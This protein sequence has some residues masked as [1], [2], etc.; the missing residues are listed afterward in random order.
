[1]YKNLTV[2][3]LLGAL[4]IILGAFGAHTLKDK[5]TPEAMQSFET[6]IR[7]QMY[8]IIILLVINLYKDFSSSFKKKM[9]YL[10][11][12]GTLFFSGSIYLIQLLKIPAKLIWFLTPLGG[13]LFIVG[14]LF[15]GYEFYQKRT[16]K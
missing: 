10:F 4:T 8:H 16:E 11:L 7:Y 3:S 12:L 2:V 15:L 9:T 14:W 6:A 1:M 5:L 13:L